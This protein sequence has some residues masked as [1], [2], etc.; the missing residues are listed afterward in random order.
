MYRQEVQTKL[1]GI[2]RE[3]FDDPSLVV[4]DQLTAADVDGWD[5]LTHVD[6]IVAVEE[7]FKIRLST[8]DVR[9]LKNVGSF[10]D[11]IAAKAK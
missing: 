4:S 5:S 3:F 6:L 10:V 2:M 7:E 1:T 11:L 8:G 9:G